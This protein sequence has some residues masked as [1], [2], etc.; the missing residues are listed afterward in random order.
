M[1]K[2]SKAFKATTAPALT[3]VGKKG[4]AVNGTN[5]RRFLK[6]GD[7]TVSSVSYDT[8]T[9]QNAQTAKPL[10]TGKPKGRGK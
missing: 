7:N 6:K 3:S 2:A 9:G 4:I 1:R 10:P 5:Q 8:P